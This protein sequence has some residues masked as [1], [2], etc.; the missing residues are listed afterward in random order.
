MKRSVIIIFNLLFPL[1]M[2]AQETNSS[3][4][5]TLRK[6]ALNIYMEASEYLKKEIPYVNYVRDRKVADVVIIST[7][8]VTGSGGEEYT[9]FMEG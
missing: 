8:Q 3:G 2:F 9:Y 7:R 6:D 1:I 5:D 4:S